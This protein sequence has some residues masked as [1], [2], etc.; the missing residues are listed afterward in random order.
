[1]VRNPIRGVGGTCTHQWRRVMVRFMAAGKKLMVAQTLGHRLDT[2]GWRG[3][4]GDGESRGTVGLPG[5][6]RS[7]VVNGDPCRRRQWR[8][9][10]QLPVLVADYLS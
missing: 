2:S 9:E 1:V 8:S 4:V 7:T 3:T 6:G 10:W 5:G